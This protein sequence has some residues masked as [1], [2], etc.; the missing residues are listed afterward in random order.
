M[1]GLYIVRPDED[2]VRSSTLTATSEQ[3]GY[4]ATKAATDD[5]SAP[6][7]ANST[8]ATLTVTFGATREVGLIA[9]VMTNADAAKTITIA[10]G[11]TGSPTLTGARE[12]SNYPKDLVYI[13]DPP[14]NLTAVT[15]AIS[16]NTNKWS[17]GRVVIGKRRT[18]GRTFTVGAYSPGRAR[19]QY[20]DENAFGHDI[21]YDM[22][23]ERATIK[24]SL[25]LY[26]SGDLATFQDAYSATKHGYLPALVVPNVNYTT[27]YPPLFCRFPASLE[28]DYYAPNMAKVD[29]SLVE[30]AKGI[31]VVD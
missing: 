12:G 15:L 24:G 17:I 22:G 30:V 1:A 9:L 3:T 27:R 4:E 21:R 25:S 11:I 28:Y 23:V 16:S 7:I 26:H 29:L 10:G 13:V 31:E 8:S 5:P 19:I 14:Q 6:W 2:W 20:T 18:L